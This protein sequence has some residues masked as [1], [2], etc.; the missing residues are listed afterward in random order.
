MADLESKALAKQLRQDRALAR[1]QARQ[2]RQELASELALERVKARSQ[3]GAWLQER[4]ATLGRSRKLMLLICLPLTLALTG[5]AA[6][7]MTVLSPPSPNPLLSS[8]GVFVCL[9][10]TMMLVVGAIITA[11]DTTRS[12]TQDALDT[13]QLKRARATSQGSVALGALEE[14][15]GEGEE[16]GAV[17]LSEGA[18]EGAL[19]GAEREASGR[20]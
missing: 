1:A 7:G 12:I 19:S 20:Q 4:G 2:A 9:G 16:R 17:S 13:R 8:M 11:L 14:V 6:L 10:S 3:R 15:R 18:L 5:I